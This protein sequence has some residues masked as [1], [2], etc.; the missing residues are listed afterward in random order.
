VQS[1]SSGTIC[2]AGS[3]KSCGFRDPASIDDFR[4]D[5]RG[6]NRAMVGCL[7]TGMKSAVPLWDAAPSVAACSSLTFGDIPLAAK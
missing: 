7:A 2:S 1:E 4:D 5:I 3:L 6:F